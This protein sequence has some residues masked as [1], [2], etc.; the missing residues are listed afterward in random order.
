MII[1]DGRTRGETEQVCQA[2]FSSGVGDD[3]NN[4]EMPEGF[5]HRTLTQKYLD[6]TN[7]ENDSAL[8]HRHLIE[9]LW[10]IFGNSIISQEESD[11]F[12]NKKNY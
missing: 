3:S 7:K 11:A 10:N 1:E 8:L 9:H 5:L 4:I 2:E 12:F 6:I